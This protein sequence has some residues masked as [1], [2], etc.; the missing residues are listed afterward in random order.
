MSSTSSTPRL[1]DPL[2]HAGAHSPPT[3]NWQRY[4]HRRPVKPGERL[5]ATSSP[6]SSPRRERSVEQLSCPLASRPEWTRRYLLPVWE[7]EAIRS[8]LKGAAYLGTDRARRL[9]QRLDVERT[10]FL[11]PEQ[12]RRVVRLKLRVKETHVSNEDLSNLS[13]MLDFDEC[14]MVRVDNFIAFVLGKQEVLWKPVRDAKTLATQLGSTSS[15]VQ[16]RAT[17]DSRLSSRSPS[18]KTLRP[19]QI[20]GLPLAQFPRS[21]SPSP[22]R[23][24]MNM[25]AKSAQTPFSFEKEVLRCCHSGNLGRLRRLLASKGAKPLDDDLGCTC[26]HLAVHLGDEELV[27]LLLR[28]HVD[29]NCRAQSGASLLLRAA[30]HGHKAIVRNLL[31]NWRVNPMGVDDKGRT[32]L[33]T[34]CCQDLGTLELLAEH[35]PM[36]MH[37][38]DALG[39]SCLFYALANPNSDEQARILQYLLRNGCDPNAP[40][41]YGCTPL[42]YA[43]EA[44]NDAAAS[45]LLCAGADPEMMAATSTIEGIGEEGRQGRNLKKPSLRRMNTC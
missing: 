29:P 44:G 11:T 25:P 22:M 31:T 18:P 1:W 5:E 33:H 30:L 14:G 37:I 43:T 28:S 40:D 2:P 36:A 32:A 42:W 38:I 15:T 17:V 13:F 19:E 6:P 39:R 9:K 41:D 4:S 23:V 8:R 3:P 7:I 27:G 35:S 12:L 10:G 24:R 20:P 34:A 45:L 21:R 26:A 16:T